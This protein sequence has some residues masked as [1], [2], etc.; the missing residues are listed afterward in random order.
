MDFHQGDER[1]NG[2]RY[3]R[4]GSRRQRHFDGTNLKPRKLLENAETPTRQVHALLARVIVNRRKTQK[5]E[6]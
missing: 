2:V 1:A 3:P 5:K 6:F 4:V